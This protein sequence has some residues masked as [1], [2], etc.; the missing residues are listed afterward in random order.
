MKKLKKVIILL[1]SLLMVI[2]LTACASTSK[3]DAN[4]EN[5]LET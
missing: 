4:K 1:L 3:N 5:G 2:G